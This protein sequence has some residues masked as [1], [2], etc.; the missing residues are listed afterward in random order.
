[1]TVNRYFSNY[2]ASSLDIP[3]ITVTNLSTNPDLNENLNFELDFN[4]D[5]DIQNFDADGYS[6]FEFNVIFITGSSDKS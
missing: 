5:P 1:M 2:E 3:G 4:N 6:L